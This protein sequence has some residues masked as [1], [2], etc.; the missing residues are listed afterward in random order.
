[1]RC[2]CPECGTYMIHADSMQTGCVCPD[3][4]H[5]CRD[6]LGTNTVM[7]KEYIEMLRQNPSLWQRE[8]EDEDY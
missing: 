8:D 7:S 1:M 6:C 3:C 2:G 4:G 5:R